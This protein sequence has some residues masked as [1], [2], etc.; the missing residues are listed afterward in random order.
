M[1]K[2]IKG[3]KAFFMGIWHIIDKFIV[4]P[5]T[6]LVL[7]INGKL[8]KSGRKFE[9]WI[10]KRSTL[11]FISLAFAVIMF[12]VVDQKI[13]F[14]S[15]SSAEVLSG[16]AVTAMYNSEAYFIEGLPE[17]VDIVLIGNKADLY[18][19]K[20][21]VVGNVV[22]DLT[23]FTGTIDGVTKDVN[24]EYS[25]GLS[26]VDYKV[27]PS[28]VSV[29]IY[30]KDSLAT[31]MT[32]EILNSDHLD[33]KI[34]IEN[35]SIDDNN[36]IIKGAKKYI[37]EVAVVKALVDMDNLT[38]QE[39]GT[40]VLE[41]VPLKAY[42]KDGNIVD[43][44]LVPSTTN[45]KVTVSESKKLVPIKAIPEGEVA[46]GLAISTIELSEKEVWIYGSKEDLQNISYVPINIDVN[47]LSQNK[48]YKMELSKPTGVKT[49]SINNVNVTVNVD[50]V[51]T[52]DIDG[53][54]I[55]GINVGEGLKATATSKE[56]G[57]ITV[58]IK[59]V[60]SVIENISSDDIIAYVDL[61][62]LGVGTHNVQLQIEQSDVKVEYV[63]KKATVSIQ[64][65]SK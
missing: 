64:I 2:I 49:M 23:R 17:T 50:S 42:D 13:I 9:N 10:S 60:N 7:F 47:Q 34:S 5:I 59:G 52:K 54:T 53:V 61:K 12:I 58:T 25:R 55:N 32:P 26:A 36:V 57:N 44:E 46:F 18:I 41:N 24:I 19:A 43:V 33:D 4:I 48:E 20:Q 15:E 39:E 29:T 38:L 30:K 16:Q 8:S 51:A 14:Y 40:Q 27:N 62:G 6:K 21:S 28:T 1:K 63:P 11:L 65:T 56:E 31:T 37:K 35:V 22:V 45:V 3:I